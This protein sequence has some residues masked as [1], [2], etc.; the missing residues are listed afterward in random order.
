LTFH[1]S[2]KARYTSGF[3]APSGA[4][5]HGALGW[6]I[7]LG[8][9]EFG[10]NIFHGGNRESAGNKALKNDRPTPCKQCPMP[11]FA[12]DVAERQFPRKG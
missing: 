8:K 9:N 7:V 3:T 6:S 12:V 5:C 1:D 10:K 2:E 4:G 11:G